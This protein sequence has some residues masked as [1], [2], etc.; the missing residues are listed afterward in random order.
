MSEKTAGGEWN[1][2]SQPR[3]PARHSAA[4]PPGCAA[5][6]ASAAEGGHLEAVLNALPQEARVRADGHHGAE[7]EPT[8]VVDPR[9]LKHPGRLRRRQHEKQ[10]D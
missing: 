6:A 3:P 5:A 1:S 7:G 8:G 9:H 10:A 4:R 2:R